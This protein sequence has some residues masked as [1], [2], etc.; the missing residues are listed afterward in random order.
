MHLTY[1]Q[2]T[3]WPL[4]KII[5]SR[6]LATFCLLTLSSC[7][8]L[9]KIEEKASNIN[10]YEKKSLVMAKEIRQLKQELQEKSFHMMYYLQSIHLI[11]LYHQQEINHSLT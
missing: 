8:F 10:Q 6:I 1:R 7:N 5:R 9:D 11:R 3:K 4:K 2:K